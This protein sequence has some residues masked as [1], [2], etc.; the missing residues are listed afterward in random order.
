M[1]CSRRRRSVS[2]ATRDDLFELEGAMPCGVL[3]E[4]VLPG[5]EA[6]VSVFRLGHVLEYVSYFDRIGGQEDLF[7]WG[8]EIFDT[9]PGIG[10]DRSSARGR[11]EESNG[12]GVARDDHVVAREIQGETR[13]RVEGG[14]FGRREMDKALHV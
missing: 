3:G 12:G 14:V 4:D 13:R 8:E 11:F 7:T 9:G 10:D 5:A 1:S 2:D 6:N